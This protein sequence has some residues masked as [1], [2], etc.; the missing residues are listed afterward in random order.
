MSGKTMLMKRCL[1]QPFTESYMTTMVVEPIEVQYKDCS[2]IWWDT[3]SQN[4]LLQHNQYPLR[5]ANKVVVC[6]DARSQESFESACDMMDDLE[7]EYVIRVA[8]FGDLGCDARD[9]DDLLVSAKT[10]DGILDLMTLL[11]DGSE[12]VHTTRGLLWSSVCF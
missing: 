3:S 1:F 6:Y 7:C 12:V 4:T 2:Y 10:G 8:T 11:Y 9:P 5:H